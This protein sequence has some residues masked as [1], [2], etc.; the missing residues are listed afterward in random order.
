[1]GATTDIKQDISTY[2]EKEIQILKEILVKTSPTLM[3]IKKVKS[4]YRENPLLQPAKKIFENEHIYKDTLNET[5]V[6]K[7]SVVTFESLASKARFLRMTNKDQQQGSGKYRQV[8]LP[9]AIKRLQ[10]WNNAG[11][12]EKELPIRPPRKK[13]KACSGLIVTPVPR[14]PAKQLET[15]T[16]KLQD[17]NQGNDPTKKRNGDITGRIDDKAIGQ[18][19]RSQGNLT[20][21]IGNA[22]MAITNAGFTVKMKISDISISG[23]ADDVSTFVSKVSKPLIGNEGFSTKT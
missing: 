22:D 8:K 15:S 2:D 11:D 19:D 9:R 1:M 5:S 7:Q 18:C 20:V 17:N 14:N 23:Q 16:M 3:N 13:S 21:K 6:E 10:D 12:K 4:S